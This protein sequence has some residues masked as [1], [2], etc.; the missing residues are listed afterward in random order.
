MSEEDRRYSPSNDFRFLV[1]N[2]NDV[3][4]VVSMTGEFLYVN[5]RGYELTGYADADRATTTLT[6][7]IPTEEVERVLSLRAARHDGETSAERYETTLLDRTGR[8]IPVEVTATPTTWEGVPADLVIL[9]D[10]SER[11]RAEDEL[12]RRDAVLEAMSDITGRFLD[13]P[14]GAEQISDA[15]ERLGHAMEAHR[16]Y[17]YEAVSDD[18][19]DISLNYRSNWVHPSHNIEGDLPSE[20]SFPMR[21][22]GLGPWV[23][24]YQQGQAVQNVASDFPEPI[25]KRVESLGIRA[26]INVP[27]L[28]EREWRAIL[29]LCDCRTERRWARIEVEALQS[30]ANVLGALMRRQEVEQALRSSESKYKSLVEATDQVIA[31]VDW[32]GVFQFANTAAAVGFRIPVEDIVGKTMWD[33]FPK[34]IADRQMTSI[35]TAMESGKLRVTE[36]LTVVR[37]E[38][39]W[40]EA[41][42]QPL[43][44]RPGPSRSAYV[45]T[46][47]ITERKATEEKIL[48][49]QERLR[50]LTSDLVLTEE[51]ERRRIAGL[52]HDRIGQAL[53]ISKMKLG[54]ISTEAE[55]E[56]AGSSLT[57][58][59]KLIDQTI[60]DTRSLTF[61]LSPPVLYELGFE[62][63]V[64][65]LVDR[66]RSDYSIEAEF[67]DDGRPKP[68]G[69]DCRVLLFQSVRELLM[70]VIRH[71]QAK[72]VSVSLQR[73]QDDIVIRTTDDGIGFDVAEIESIGPES[74]GFGLFNIREH[75][76]QLGGR[77]VFN[78]KVGEG[79]QIVLR[80][81]CL[82][83]TESKG[84]ESK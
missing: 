63:G 23:E 13:S 38:E 82:K 18:G 75:L 2:A 31:V 39:R 43:P 16:V 65:W 80:A 72:R 78:S 53:A 46:T 8:K 56:S 36:A 48:S 29:G 60:E 66:L 22:V 4:A 21:S 58:I 10:I 26:S 32:D 3:I 30:A 77:A 11:R 24:K 6:D 55:S 34:E 84:D 52:L 14:V 1:D 42:I 73:E 27:I 37:G 54:A 79:A 76:S 59:Q 57:E 12:R 19:S 70:N 49:Y 47:D 64:E 67:S 15:L 69:N 40:Y 81:P 35:R 17:L 41:R 50:S 44:E 61:E 28:V 74:S 71:S 5:R 20:R 25:R 68:L 7:L 33:L 51:R 9:R 45:V 83:G 62:A